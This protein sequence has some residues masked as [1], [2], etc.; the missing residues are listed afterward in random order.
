MTRETFDIARNILADIESLKNIKCEYEARHWVSFYGAEV[1]EQPITNGTLRA[2]LK[3][4]I[5]DEIVKLEKE[6]EKL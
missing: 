4:F 2:D 1:K 3:K 6:L 5:D